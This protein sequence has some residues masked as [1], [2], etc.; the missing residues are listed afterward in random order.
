MNIK[1]ILLLL[2]FNGC[3]SKNDMPS[4]KDNVKSNI[5]DC[6]ILFDKALSSQTYDN[7]KASEIMFIKLIDETIN[8]D[9]LF[10]PPYIVK[11]DFLIR[12]KKYSQAVIN[13]EQ[14]PVDDPKIALQKAYCYNKIEDT[15]QSEKYQNIALEYYQLNFEKENS[16]VNLFHLLHVQSSVLP[17]SVA[18]NTLNQNKKILS[19]NELQYF[20]DILDHH[21][22]VDPDDKYIIYT[23]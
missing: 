18:R 20:L 8:C 1:I 23:K 19:Q 5:E 9:S 6:N 16:F 21:F 10:L 11:S 3:K 4:F 2:F 12:E 14:F 7:N 15:I 22:M 13:L 17:L